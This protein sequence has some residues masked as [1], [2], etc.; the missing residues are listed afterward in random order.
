L[1]FINT[2]KRIELK[3]VFKVGDENLIY[4]FLHSSKFSF[5]EIYPKRQIN[6][7]YFDNFN[8]SS[9]ENSIEG[10][11]ERT[12]T[13]IRWYGT[14]TKTNKASLEIKLK[15]GFYSWKIITK[16][17]YTVNP[18]A[19][20]WDTFY[21]NNGLKQNIHTANLNFLKPT[22]IVSYERSY[23]SNYDRNLRVTL[24]RNLVSFDQRL[25]TH[26]SYL[27]KKNHH[28]LLILEVKTDACHEDL[29][30]SFI[31]DIPFSGRRFSK[32][33]ESLQAWY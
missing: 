6:S 13:R 12:K 2:P 1:E 33:C 10:S 26:P 18:K 9:Y 11:S 29:V 22:S 19:L 27:Y 32:Y 17:F 5:R 31:K 25:S 30:S 15:K 8:H 24:D 21:L 7:L 20:R 14:K 16:N 28:G 4:H 23:F 3:D